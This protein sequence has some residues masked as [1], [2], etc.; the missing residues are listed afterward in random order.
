MISLSVDLYPCLI[1][2]RLGSNTTHLQHVSVPSQP[3]F[4][5]SLRL[6]CE[7]CFQTFMPPQE[8]IYLPGSSGTCCWTSETVPEDFKLCWIREKTW[9]HN[10]A[11]LFWKEK[12]WL[13][14]PPSPQTIF[15][16]CA[17]LTHNVKSW[18]LSLNHTDHG[19]VAW[20]ITTEKFWSRWKKQRNKALIFLIPLLPMRRNALLFDHNAFHRE[21]LRAV[22]A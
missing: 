8:A 4:P 13:L 19:M 17:C 10:P 15:F 1:L 6:R 18:E 22:D 5:L 12:F 2:S 21:G 9:L 7:C 14:L 3:T 11:I 20:I 16:F